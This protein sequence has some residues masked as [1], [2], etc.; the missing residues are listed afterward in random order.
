MTS[1]AERVGNGHRGNNH[2]CVA[3]WLLAWRCPSFG[4]LTSGCTDQKEQWPSKSTARKGKPV[5]WPVLQRREEENRPPEMW[6]DQFACKHGASCI[7]ATLDWPSACRRPYWRKLAG[8][9]ECD[10][11]G[12]LMMRRPSGRHPS[13]REGSGSCCSGV[14]TPNKKCP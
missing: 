10:E 13:E 7:E 9:A 3:S 8:G 1:E 14:K 11:S 5:R 2:M 12:I 4:L 6:R